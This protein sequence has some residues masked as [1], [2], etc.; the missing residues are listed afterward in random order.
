[1]SWQSGKG[2][3]R[4]GPWGG[5]PKPGSKTPNTSFDDLIRQGQ[6]W[7]GRIMPGGGSPRTTIVLGIL[8]LAGFGAWTAYYTVPSDSVAVVQRFAKRHPQMSWV[9]FT[10]ERSVRWDKSRLWHAP[11]V[12]RDAVPAE[13]DTAGW[14]A[15]CQH[16]FKLPSD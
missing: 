8:A 9:I 16:I 1:M 10:P 5:G 13:G 6:G 4:D 2:G 7:L 11:G 3:G 12:A 15:C 14:L